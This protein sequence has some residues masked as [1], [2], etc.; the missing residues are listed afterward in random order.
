MLVGGVES[1][2]RAPWVL[3]KPERAFPAAGA[4]LVS[5]TL[6]WRLVNPAMP[7]VW[8]VSLGEA[9]E[10]LAEREGIFREDQDAF[11]LRS[12]RAAAGA[13][14]RGFY[15]NQ[16]IEVPGVGPIRDESIRATTPQALAGLAPVFRP[17]GTVTAGNA[18]PRTCSTAPGRR[19]RRAS[20][21]R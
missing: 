21:T 17:D 18:S 9:T 16:V 12:H 15:A 7:A 20:P 11:A 14:D 1:M 5:T 4:E 8:T 6:G 3:P 10:Q 19:T 2:S 13:W